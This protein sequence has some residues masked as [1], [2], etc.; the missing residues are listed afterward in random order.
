MYPNP[1]PLTRTWAGVQ[2]LQF[3]PA[4]GGRLE[5]L[6]WYPIRSSWLWVDCATLCK[7]HEGIMFSIIQASNCSLSPKSL[8]EPPGLSGTNYT[9]SQ[10]VCASA[11][12]RAAEKQPCRSASRSKEELG[13]IPT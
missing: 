8:L 12:A 13:P 3:V 10:G 4:K 5:Q 11:A 9:N 2:S 6:F 7:D 1:K